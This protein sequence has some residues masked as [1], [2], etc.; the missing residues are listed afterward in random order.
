MPELIPA[1]PGT[2][3]WL[4]ARR[5]GVTATDIVT[6]LGLSSWDSAYSLYWRKLGQVPEVPDNDRFRLGRYLEDYIAERWLGGGDPD[7]LE[8]SGLYRHSERAW[9]MA[10][11]DRMTPDVPGAAVPTVLELKSWAD[12]ARHAWDDGPPAAVRAQVLWQMNVMDVGT[13]HVGVVF[14]PSGEFRSCV[15][16]HDGELDCAFH[17]HVTDV[18]ACQ[19]CQDQDLMRL[20]G[21]EFYARL[22]GELP[23]PDID[24]SAAS[25][26]AVK[27]RFG[28]ARKD[29]VVTV[30]TDLWETYSSALIAR[31][32]VE[33]EVREPEAQIRELIGEAGAIEVDGQLVARHL[34]YDAQ[35]KA[36]TRHIDSIRRVKQ[37]G[38]DSE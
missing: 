21:A 23:P 26:A 30:P 3:G 31:R 1:E 16:E 9:Q 28:S 37:Q 8:P 11:V 12:A 36:H 33:E 18:G 34:V 32:L 6:I 7:W 22:Q 14:L 35:V 24:A 13:G 19:V 20:R 5:Q 29:K 4:A 15:I 27:A 17:G 10:T 38:D 2:P 25:L